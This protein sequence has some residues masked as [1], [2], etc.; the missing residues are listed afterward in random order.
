M[1]FMQ[2]PIAL[3]CAYN[4]EKHIK[5][6]IEKTLKHIKKVIVVND[7]SKDST[8]KEIKKTK[9]IL[10]NHEVNKGKGEALKTGFEYCLKNNY[11]PIILLDTDGQHDPSEIPKFIEKINEGYDIVI[12]TRKKRYS[13]M[14]LHRRLTNFLSSSMLSLVMKQYVKDTQSGYRAINLN[15]LRNMKFIS[16]RYDLESELLVKASRKGFKITNVPIR[17]IYGE[18]KSTIHPIKDTL[19]FFR[20]LYRAIFK[21]N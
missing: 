18:E 2:K 4:E 21:W 1:F 7:G 11:N 16:K 20:L 17:V 10:L 3:I 12:G 14:P 15:V 5:D 6:T 19:R 8:L 9:A 13:Q